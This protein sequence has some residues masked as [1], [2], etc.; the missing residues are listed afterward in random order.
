MDDEAQ[1]NAVHKLLK[2]KARNFIGQY[3]LLLFKGGRRVDKC[4]DHIEK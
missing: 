4:G 3:Y 1:Q 2:R